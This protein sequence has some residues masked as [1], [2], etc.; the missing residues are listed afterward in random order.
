MVACTP[1]MMFA[2]VIQFSAAVFFCRLEMLCHLFYS[3]SQSYGRS[4][5][6]TTFSKK[7]IFRTS[8]HLD[9][10]ISTVILFLIKVEE[11]NRFLSLQCSSYQCQ[12]NCLGR[13]NELLRK[14]LEL[15]F[16]NKMDNS[17]G[18]LVFLFMNWRTYF[19]I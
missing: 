19:E 4:S 13:H 14:P 9:V 18:R 16:Q 7:I 1:F 11:L 12:V 15:V 10:T 5:N 2:R 17:C 6:I 3:L 8:S